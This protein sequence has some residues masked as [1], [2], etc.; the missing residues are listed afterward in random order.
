[1]KN[2]N[3]LASSTEGS[4]TSSNDLEKQKPNKKLDYS[5]LMYNIMNIKND[6]K[7]IRD[8]FTQ[9]NCI[10]EKKMKDKMKMNITYEKEFKDHLQKKLNKL[11]NRLNILQ[12]KYNGYKMWYDRFNI[13]IIIISSLLSIFEALRNEMREKIENNENMIIFF[14]MV[15]IG[16]SSGITCSAAIIKF[17]KYQEKMENMQFTREKVILA[18]SKLKHVQE[19][20]WFNHDDE[21]NEIKK[22]YLEEIYL[23]YNESNSELERHIK[24][25]DHHKFY[26]MY[27]KRPQKKEK[28]NIIYS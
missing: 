21:F 14:N 23:I 3:S 13:M 25:N 28:K 12:M 20:L 2:M 5:H 9:R 1:M 24:F 11:D 8:R 7:E 17:K 19:S 6:T 18:I 10:Y 4:R 26:K 15:P 16:I 22:R 27:Q